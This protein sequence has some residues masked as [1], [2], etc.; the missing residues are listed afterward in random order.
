[1][2]QAVNPWHNSNIALLYQKIGWGRCGVL[3]RR[4]ENTC[5]SELPQGRYPHLSQLMSWPWSHKAVPNLQHAVL[6]LWFLWQTWVQGRM[7]SELSR[8]CEFSDVAAGLPVLSLPCTSPHYHNSAALRGWD[9]WGEFTAHAFKHRIWAG[10]KSKPNSHTK[11]WGTA[12]QMILVSSNCRLWIG[13]KVKPSALCCWGCFPRRWQN[14]ADWTCLQGAQG[15]LLP[16]TQAQPLSFT[17][18]HTKTDTCDLL[19]PHIHCKF[20][21]LLKGRIL[22]LCQRYRQYLHCWLQRLS[23][24]LH[25]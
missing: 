17:A 5:S 11:C 21:E 24:C 23:W 19:C 8:H 3:A 10:W 16:S 14:L 18:S 15:R 20:Q 7:K 12:V 6:C 13:G 2:S 25:A 9:V 4:Q 1:M 22:L